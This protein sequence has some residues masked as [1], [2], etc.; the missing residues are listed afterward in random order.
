MQD[1]RVEL[2]QSTTDR[3]WQLAV[4][5]GG[6]DVSERI[7]ATTM[8]A[9]RGYLPS[10]HRA[11]A[12]I[13]RQR[14]YTL[15]RYLE[16]RTYFSM[17]NNPIPRQ[18]LV[19]A[20]R[21]YVTDSAVE[22]SGESYI[23]AIES[24][25]DI[26]ENLVAS[27][28]AILSMGGRI[29]RLSTVAESGAPVKLLDRMRK[30]AAKAIATQREAL[31]ANAKREATLIRSQV[32]MERAAFELEKRRWQQDVGRQFIVPEW[33][34]GYP[35]RRHNDGII[36]VQLRF[37]YQP[38]EFVWPGYEFR[39]QRA[40]TYRWDAMAA[41]LIPVYFW[42]RFELAS[43][44]YS[45][46][47]AHIDRLSPIL[48]H[49]TQNSF[50]CQPQGLPERIR[51][52]ADLQ[53]VVSAITRTFRTVNLSSLLSSIH[54]WTPEVKAF[55][56]ERLREFLVE[57]FNEDH[58]PDP[59]EYGATRVGRERATEIWSVEAPATPTR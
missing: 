11:Y 46:E 36:S 59:R 50:C 19:D 32:E 55:E 53:M 25:M 28:P 4:T 22:L 31:I 6:R 5:I 42:L 33:L 18:A 43:G 17:E 58:R 23:S 13:D 2:S 44:I 7:L 37:F 26:A 45:L 9:F 20:I 41:D 30:Q 51:R 38:T 39:L 29:F 47:S 40:A 35:V 1:I 49:A 48:P 56:P 12:N 52:E 8:I 54:D 14:N 16:G 21:A 15:E 34:G 3:R 24:D 10:Q 57:Y 27:Q